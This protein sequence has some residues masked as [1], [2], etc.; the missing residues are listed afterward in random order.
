ML[1][2]FSHRQYKTLFIID[3]SDLSLKKN[4]H[5]KAQQQSG[6][7]F[8]REIFSLI[9]IS[10]ID[11]QHISSCKLVRSPQ[12]MYSGWSSHKVSTFV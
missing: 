4:Q 12:G 10:A 3:I 7:L 11:L 1:R 9:G 5:N 6:Y 8:S 2:L